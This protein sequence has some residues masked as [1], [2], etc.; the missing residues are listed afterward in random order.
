MLSELSLSLS[1][2]CVRK[3]NKWLVRMML[4]GVSLSKPHSSVTALRMCVY[5]L[6]ALLVC[7]G[8]TTYCNFK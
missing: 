8:P 1:L 2:Y 5:M 7:F 4:I 3:A 6:V